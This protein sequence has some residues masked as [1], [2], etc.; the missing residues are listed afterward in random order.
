MPGWW[1]CCEE[2][3]SGSP[4]LSGEKSRKSFTTENFGFFLGVQGLTADCLHS[5]N[6]RVDGTSEIGS[7]LVFP[8]GAMQE[9]ETVYRLMSDAPPT[10][11]SYGDGDLGLKS[12][13]KDQ[14]SGDLNLQ[15]L[16]W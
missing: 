11:R 12:H 2:S 6:V 7:I 1:T 15:I 3:T 4:R 16:D 10:R 13:P 5:V 14:L 8:P 9:R